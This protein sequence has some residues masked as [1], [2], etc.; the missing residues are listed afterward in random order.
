MSQKP[1]RVAYCPISQSLDVFGDKW[2]LLIIREMTLF[3]KNTYGDFLKMEEKIATNILAD[4]LVNLEKAGIITKEVF[5]GSKSKFLYKL[6]HKGIDL[7]PIIIEL[8]SWGNKYFSIHPL[9]NDLSEKIKADKD[10]FK[11]KLTAGLTT[12]LT[13]YQSE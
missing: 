11:R 7:V 12:E 5:A 4:R 9:L 8:F 2:S 1:D 13:R 3:K 10:K 6:T